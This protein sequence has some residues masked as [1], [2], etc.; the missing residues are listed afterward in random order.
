MTKEKPKAKGLWIHRFAIRFFTVALTILIFWL[1]SFVVTD[2]E[3]IE[4]PDRWDIEKKYL[5]QALV[6]KQKA[7]EKTIAKTTRQ[8]DERKSKQGILGDSIRSLQKTIAQLLDLRQL[9]M[10]KNLSFSELEQKAFADSLNLFLENQKRYQA[11]NRDIATLVDEKNSLQAEVRHIKTTL[12]KQRRPAWT[13]Y[14]RLSRKHELKLAFL[15]LLILIP[16]LIVAVSLI[17]RKRSSIYFPIPL[18]LGIS[19][20][21]KVSLVMHEYFPSRFFKYGLIVVVLLGVMKLLSYFIKS[22]AFPKKQWLIKQYREAYERF[23]CP[24][25][26]YP[27]KR[28]PMK[29]LF[30]NRRSIGKLR[31]PT[32]AS[33]DES[34]YVCPACGTAL[35]DECASCHKTRHSLL[36]HCEHC[37]EETT[38]MG[39]S[40][41]PVATN[42]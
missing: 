30:W 1:L 5:D 12:E 20:F 16:I 4:G 29:F 25:C 22:I 26:E 19:T 14:Y 11:I 13:E 6:A 35:F 2:I 28:G 34:S 41:N 32:E 24:I 17:I 7:L 31:L 38:L 23:L 27:I 21:L 40:P 3:S 8:I 42:A 10:Q 36:P 33:G 9:G 37:G 39:E 15:Q 18:A